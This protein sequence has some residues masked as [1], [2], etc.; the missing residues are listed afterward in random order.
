MAPFR[1]AALFAGSAQAGANPSETAMERDYA[2]LKAEI[3]KT[4]ETA[5]AERLRTLS[6]ALV[7]SQA[8]SV[9]TLSLLSIVLFALAWFMREN[10]IGPLE[11]LRRSVAGAARG[12]IAL[13]IW[14]VE[15]KDEIGAVA[16]AAEMMR[17][18]AVAAA[19]PADPQPLSRMVERL[20]RGIVRLEAELAQM[21]TIAGH[22][23][24]RIE[25][26]GLR[27]A[28][29]SHAAAQAANLAYEG[30]AR[31]TQRSQ[32]GLRDAN[33]YTKAVLTS[34]AETLE[35]LAHAAATLDRNIASAT[36]MTP[37]QTPA[38][39][40]QDETRTYE[41]AD[42]LDDL[43]E[44]LEALEYFVQSRKDLGGEEAA[45]LNAALIGAID[46]LNAVAGHVRPGHLA[47]N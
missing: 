33:V 44:N 41:A 18:A 21:A 1:R 43:V 9:V 32:T 46:R 35:R 13:P 3:A 25:D 36:Q 12:N 6:E 11:A 40:A 31:M 16:R 5:S 7:W 38:E 27:A 47:A 15:R 24:M 29:A 14:G 39:S 34:V 4:M 10:L 19:K 28:K 42:V 37:P 22:A 20:N 45:S 26:A 17:Q 30:A 8:A 23:R 2:G